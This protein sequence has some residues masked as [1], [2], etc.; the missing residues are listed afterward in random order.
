M[1]KITLEEILE[2]RKE[3]KN[4]PMEKKKKCTTCKKKKK[5]ITEM[6]PLEDLP[7]IP[8]Q[9]DIIEA[10][11]EL[12]SYH[13]VKEDKKEFISKVY[14][15]IFNEEMVYDCNVCVSTQARKFKH[16]ITQ[17]LKLNV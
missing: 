5:E 9:K 2:L 17:V 16:Y 8:D 14:K 13:G 3:N 11:Y 1:E 4:K 6:I 12:T 10:Y 7:Y 15:E